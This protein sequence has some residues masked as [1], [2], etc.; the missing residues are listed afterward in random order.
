MA[1]TRSENG[2]LAMIVDI[3]RVAQKALKHFASALHPQAI[4]IF[5]PLPNPV[6]LDSCN[7]NTIT[8]HPIRCSKTS[9][10]H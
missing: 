10:R 1:L 4:R 8:R 2:R 6:P 9:T 5:T 3:D 7:I